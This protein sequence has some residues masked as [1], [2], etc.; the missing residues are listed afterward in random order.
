MGG[1]NDCINLT[2]PFYEFG[3]GKG[4]TVAN[5][6]HF[7][8]RSW[9]IRV[10]SKVKKTE[11]IFDDTMKT[12]KLPQQKTESLVTVVELNRITSSGSL[13]PKF[14]LFRQRPSGSL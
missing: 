4:N 11:R 7:K 2:I 10:E 13:R 8:L 3:T 12:R 5:A 9:I 6:T 14:D 1:Y